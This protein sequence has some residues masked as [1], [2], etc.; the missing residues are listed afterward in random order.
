[1]G[2]YI[3]HY[4]RT[5]PFDALLGGGVCHSFSQAISSE[6]TDG[7]WIYHVLAE[8]VLGDLGVRQAMKKIPKN[9]RL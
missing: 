8:D 2:K 6:L 1:M 5:V 4:H 7:R 9:T 3:E